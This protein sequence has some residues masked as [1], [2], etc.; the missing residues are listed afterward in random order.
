MNNLRPITHYASLMLVFNMVLGFGSSALA[1][2]A[3]EQTFTLRMTPQ[4]GPNMQ[5]ASAAVAR[6]QYDS[7]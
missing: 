1:Q 2:A 7:L 4:Q 5:V 6:A 3:P